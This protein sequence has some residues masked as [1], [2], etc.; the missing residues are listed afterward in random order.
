MARPFSKRSSSLT[1]TWRGR[2]SSMPRSCKTSLTAL[3]ALSVLGNPMNGAHWYTAARTSSG[4]TPT[5][6]AAAV[7]ALSCGSVCS[8]GQH[9]GDE[10]TGAVGRQWESLRANGSPWRSS[11]SQCSRNAGV[12]VSELESRV[13]HAVVESATSVSFG[14]E[15][16]SDQ[17][18]V[19]A[20]SPLA[21]CH[22]A[23]V[24]WPS[25]GLL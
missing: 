1:V 2:G 6:N 14:L 3:T 8:V 21:V 19:A 16:I 18:R 20:M 12:L 10:L 15:E 4:A 11:P 7:C 22:S 24:V 9:H 5:F 25:V 13:V 17:L 23:L